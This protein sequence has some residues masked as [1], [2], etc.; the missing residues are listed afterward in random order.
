MEWYDIFVG[1]YV[2][3]N[4]LDIYVDEWAVCC[5]KMQGRNMRV[6][7]EGERCVW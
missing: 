2:Q 5:L 3:S 4:G 1:E 7:V 6:V